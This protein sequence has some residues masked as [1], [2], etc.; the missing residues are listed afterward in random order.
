MSNRRSANANVTP[1]EERGFDAKKKIRPLGFQPAA[2][3]ESSASSGYSMVDDAGD[4]GSG[5]ATM[6]GRSMPFSNMSYG[7]VVLMVITWVLLLSAFVMS[8]VAISRLDGDGHHR[9]RGLWGGCGDDEEIC[10]D[11]ET[12]EI[13]QTSKSDATFSFPVANELFGGKTNYYRGYNGTTGQECFPFPP[14]GVEMSCIQTRTSDKFSSVTTIVWK[15]SSSGIGVPG[16]EHDCSE[17]TWFVSN[18]SCFW[19]TDPSGSSFT[20]FQGVPWGSFHS[21]SGPGTFSISRGTIF[22]WGCSPG[23]LVWFSFTPGANVE[24]LIKTL[25]VDIFGPSPTLPVSR[26][27]VE[28]AAAAACTLFRNESLNAVFP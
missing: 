16:H 14:F 18:G 25:A 4:S 12:L 8:A 1:L 9:W 24:I 15:A 19:Y 3:V 27:S 13:I 7:Y 23:T 28:T 10:F 20:D 5:Y 2:G 26:Q 6:A 21:I 11:A 17:E 22:S